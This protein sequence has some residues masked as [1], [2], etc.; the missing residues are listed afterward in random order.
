[1]LLGAFKRAL[2]LAAVR[3]L[4]LARA[5]L[6]ATACAG[7]LAAAW[8]LL[9]AL[10]AGGLARNALRLFSLYAA[11]TLFNALAWQARRLLEADSAG[12]EPGLKAGLA[13][14]LRRR[15]AERSLSFL[16]LAA[17]AFWIGLALSFYRGAGLKLPLAL[18]GIVALLT[19][20]T[21]LC[22][23]GL[24]SRDPGPGMALRCS[25]AEWKA[26][27]FMALAF[28]PRC[29]AVLAS[30]F[31]LCGGGA[32]LLNFEG[33]ASRLLWAP[34]LLLPVFS[35]ACMAA[36]CVALSDEFLERALGAEK[37][38]GL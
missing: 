27:L 1:M 18:A 38:S 12:A 13:G 30:F 33:M 8:A 24:A 14:F 26:A 16:A 25:P 9:A 5:N 31:L 34:A 29:L 37:G 7:L 22:G 4:E 10:Q 19:A 15:L 23:V 6:A 28:F 32:V 3:P 2:R 36:L 21:A 11:W 17:A 35:A 20:C